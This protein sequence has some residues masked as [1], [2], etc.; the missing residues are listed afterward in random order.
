MLPWNLIRA[1]ND[2][3]ER[4]DRFQ[5]NLSSGTRLGAGAFHPVPQLGDGDGSNLDSDTVT[6]AGRSITGPFSRD[7]PPPKEW[8]VTPT[9]ENPSIAP[10]DAINEGM[11]CTIPRR[12]DEIT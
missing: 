1:W 11:L 8:P 4:D 5:I 12:T 2:R 3:E 9:F 6:R 10:D 7:P